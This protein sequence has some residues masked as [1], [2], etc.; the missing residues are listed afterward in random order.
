M[1]LPN[2]WRDIIWINADLDSYHLNAMSLF[3]HIK[4]IA[5]H[6][7][8]FVWDVITHPCH[9]FDGGLTLPSLKL[10]MYE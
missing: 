2:R 7:H 3:M 1:D 6:I 8:C 9:I 5:D 10:G 4:H